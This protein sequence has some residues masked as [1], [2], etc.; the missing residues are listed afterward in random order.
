MAEKAPADMLQ[1][2]DAE[3]LAT[4]GRLIGDHRQAVLATLDTETGGPYTAMVAYAPEPGFGGLLLHL[5]DLSA[6]KRHLRADPRSS[7]MIFQPDDGRTEILQ[8]PRVSLSGL[9]E[10]LPQD[11]GDYDVARA[12]YLARFPRHEMMFA[13]QDFDL[14]RLIP[15]AGL[16]NAGF[17]RAFRVTPAELA[18]A[19]AAAPARSSG[20][21]AHGPPSG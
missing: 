1:D 2:C 14:V 18:R 7:L 13:L 11:G 10:I 21:P 6:H 15:R 3:S 4:L 16:L 20:D 5:S 12:T 8:H 19:A 9:A 17:G